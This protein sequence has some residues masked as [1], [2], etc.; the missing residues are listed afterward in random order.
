MKNT[1]HLSIEYRALHNI[2]PLPSNTRIHDLAGIKDSIRTFGFVDPILIS[3]STG[4]DLDGNGRLEALKLMYAE[5]QPA[6]GNISVK[7]E[8]TPDSSG[9]KVPVWYAPIVQVAFDAEDEPI[10]ALRLNRAH[11]KGSYDEARVFAVLE[12]AASHE[13]LDHTGYDTALFEMLA[14]RHAPVPEF[15]APVALPPGA[16]SPA[17]ALSPGARSATTEN[18]AGAEAPTPT[19]Y[20]ATT[21]GPSHVRMIQLFL[22]ADTHPVF[23]ERAQA[24]VVSGRFHTDDGR[25]VNNLTDLVFCLMADA[26]LAHKTGAGG[27]AADNLT[28]DD[29][30]FVD[31]EDYDGE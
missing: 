19:H 2:I 10:L 14:L 21:L 17:G 18:G 26:Y 5:G 23:V 30:D 29:D 11:G 1:N 28:D 13:R 15:E 4:H 12:R 16:F 7:H 31:D 25:P 20:S 9:K 22:N 24:L 8:T 3:E 27:A 6:P